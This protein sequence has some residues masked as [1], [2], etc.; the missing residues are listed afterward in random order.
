MPAMLGTEFLA[1]GLMAGIRPGSV[2]ARIGHAAL[3]GLLSVGGAA[4]APAAAAGVGGALRIYG[5]MESRLFGRLAPEAENAAATIRQ[6]GVSESVT[7]GGPEVLD[8]SIVQKLKDMGFVKTAARGEAGAPVRGVGAAET[9]PEVS[10]GLSP[11]EMATEAAAK[12]TEAAGAENLSP[13]FAQKLDNAVQLGWKPPPGQGTRLFSKARLT[14]AAQEWGGGMV[15][16]AAKASNQRL[17]AQHTAKA[18]GMADWEKATRI[19][20]SFFAHADARIGEEF[21]AVER[22]LPAIRVDEYAASLGHIDQTETLFEKTRGQQYIEAAVKKAQARQ[23]QT[24]GNVELMQTRRQ[25]SQKMSEFYRNGD[26]ADGE[27]V[28]DALNRLDSTIEE[29]I[30]RNKYKSGLSEKWAA[31]RQ[32]WQIKSMAEHGASASSSGDIN[33]VSLMRQLRKDRAM[34]G[35]G[36]GGPAQPGA[37]RELFDLVEVA[38]DAETGVPMTG[39]R[40][41]INKAKSTAAAGALGGL[42]LGAGH[43]IWGN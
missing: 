22:R 10:R 3:G 37:A 32:Q 43:S 5:Q 13:D 23:G 15:E 41:L 36:R 35:F 30:K 39:A 6:A 28:R 33:A 24:I 31:A 21:K 40:M 34:G 8:P 29:E 20:N 1:G 19:D 12:Q 27:V 17:L 11:E 26:T 14:Q 25:L 42:G 18:M 16:Q 2:D 9:P 38:A 4:L 7:P